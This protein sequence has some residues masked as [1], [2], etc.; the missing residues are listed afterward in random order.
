MLPLPRT[1]ACEQSR[2]HSLG[3][4]DAGEL[5]RQD[6]A[7]EAR[8]G[9]IGTGLHAG[10]P[11]E[12]LDDGIVHGLVGIGPCLAPTAHRNVHDVRL[13]RLE[14]VVV[15]AQPRHHARAEVLHEN[16][17]L[18]GEIQ[19]HLPPRRRLRIHGNGALV[20]VVVH[21][22][23]GEVAL[24]VTRPP[25]MIAAQRRFHLHHV[26]ALIGED[27]GAVGAG[28]HGGEIHHADAVEGAWQGALL[29]VRL[30]G[31]AYARGGAGSI[32]SRTALAARGSWLRPHAGCRTD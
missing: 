19:D 7:D 17:R 6:G 18:L 11:G 28:D 23:G 20:A 4:R 14:I 13:H 8:P 24:A 32:R 22:G 26:R 29:V 1:F 31:G 2:A 10:Q 3:R 25:R 30:W 16:V 5:V 21:E 27:H 15:Q 12:R 9:R